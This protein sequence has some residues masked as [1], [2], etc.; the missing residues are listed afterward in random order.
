[1]MDFPTLG[2]LPKQSTQALEFIQKTGVDGKN[3]LIAILDTGVDPAAPGLQ[4][5]SDGKPKIVDCIDCTGSGDVYLGEWIPV[6][7]DIKTLS[8]KLL[9]LPPKI[10][11]IKLGLKSAVELYPKELWDRLKEKRKEKLM[12]EHLVYVNEA[13]MSLNKICEALKSKS[14]EELQEQRKEYQARIDG[15]KDLAALPDAGTVFDVV[16]YHNG[17]H[18]VAMVDKI[19]NGDFTKAK[20]MAAFGIQREFDFFSNDDELTYNFQFYGD[21]ILSIVC[22]AGSHGTH[23]AAITAANFPDSPDHNGVAPGA[24]LISLKIGDTRLG[25]METNTGLNR[26]LHCLLEYK[27]DIANMSYGEPCQFP[28]SGTFSTFLNKIINHGCIFVSSAG[29]AGPSLST[30][31][32]PGGTT[33]S[34]IS[35]GAHVHKDQIIS[36][37]PTISDPSLISNQPYTWSSRGPCMDGSSGVDIYAPGSAITS[38]PKYTLNH[39]QLMNGTSMASPNATGCIA[40]LVSAYFKDTLEKP[41]P[42]RVKHALLFNKSASFNSVEGHPFIQVVDAYDHLIKYKDLKYLDIQY[43]STGVYCRDTTLVNDPISIQLQLTWF[44]QWP[45]L[46]LPVISNNELLDLN[47]ECSLSS[48]VDCILFPKYLQLCNSKSFTI[49]LVNVP[50]GLQKGFITLFH[51]N[52]IICQIPITLIHPQSITSTFKV[53]HHSHPGCIKRHFIKNSHSNAMQVHFKSS[54]NDVFYLHCQ[55]LLPST[56]HTENEHL[57]RSNTASLTKTVVILPFTS[58]EICIAQFWS[59]MGSPMVS[60]E[61]DFTHTLVQTQL[62]CQ[63]LSIRYQTHLS[64]LSSVLKA[65]ITHQVY[66]TSPIS[67]NTTPLLKRDDLES[68]LFETISQFEFTSSNDQPITIYTPMDHSLYDNSSSVLLSVYLNKE[69]IHFQDCYPK[70]FKCKGKLTIYVQTT[71]A[72]TNTS[73]MQ[74][75]IQQEID[76]VV[77]VDEKV[78][79]NFSSQLKQQSMVEKMSKLKNGFY[80]VKVVIGQQQDSFVIHQTTFNQK[81]HS[82]DQQEGLI[83]SIMKLKIDI[84]KKKQALTQLGVDNEYSR[85]QL[86]LQG[87]SGKS[88]TVDINKLLLAHHGQENSYTLNTKSYKQLVLKQPSHLKLEEMMTLFKDMDVLEDVLII[89]NELVVRKLYGRALQVILTYLK[90][91][92]DIE[93]I[94]KLKSV[95]ELLQYKEWST[96]ISEYKIVVDRPTSGF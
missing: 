51:N 42:Y 57:I 76:P 17:S 54:T 52:L 48:D 45:L 9:T 62:N 8:G 95:L 3:T 20:A 12:K 46:D 22:V 92:R 69:R 75:K 78:K 60:L 39:S 38:I 71:N 53:N 40:L 31:G 88:N 18:L 36:E 21:S 64:P 63:Q 89:I 37:Y 77:V 30:V 56:K 74:L 43:E 29:N 85:L 79:I 70:S 87:N 83:D 65:T 24:Q 41:S 58:M 1:M 66:H 82:I 44:K 84:D 35:V 93:M 19:G 23:V 14:S 68:S 81:S 27:V 4:L 91:H 50:Q 90:D 26:A 11:K 80:V 96:R 94:D 7:K 59:S 15:L 6:T 73:A 33:H 67:I 55:Q 86:E 49:Q 5:T 2:L 61:C 28:N 10:D 72:S 32:A 13:E 47:L 16:V 25:S 34:I